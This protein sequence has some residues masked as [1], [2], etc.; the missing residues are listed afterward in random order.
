MDLDGL[1]RRSHRELRA[2]QLGNRCLLAE[3]LLVLGEPRRMKHQMLSRLDFGGDVRK[4]KLN[5]LKV[6]NRLTE[7]L[8]EGR[9]PQRLLERSFRDTKRKRRDANPPRVERSHE[10]VESFP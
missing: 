8:P 4:L 10:V 6:R 7:L 9:I 3:G 1:D 5:A 2:V